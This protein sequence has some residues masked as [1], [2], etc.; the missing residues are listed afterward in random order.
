VWS[1]SFF[2]SLRVLIA[3]KFSS[4]FGINRVDRKQVL[5]SRL[6]CYPA[7]PARHLSATGPL[8][9]TRSPVGRSGVPQCGLVVPGFRVY[10]VAQLGHVPE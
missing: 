10:R 3:I 8:Q 4:D 9:T 2:R 7:W 6:V 1:R 5:S